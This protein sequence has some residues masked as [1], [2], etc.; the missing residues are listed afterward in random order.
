MRSARRGGHLG[1][2][3]TGSSDGDPDAQGRGELGGG[4]R[5]DGQADPVAGR[6]PAADEGAG[7]GDRG[8]LVRPGQG[9]SAEAEVEVTIGAEPMTDGQREV[10]VNLLG[11]LGRSE[12]SL[13]EPLAD[14]SRPDAERLINSLQ[15]DVRRASES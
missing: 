15:A 12:E 9:G 8:A 7:A 14:Y 1:T 2:D 4:L 10:I 6:R 3:E 13:P 5:R 11:S